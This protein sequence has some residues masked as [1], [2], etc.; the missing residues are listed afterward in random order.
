MS[1]N[2]YIGEASIAYSIED[3]E[4]YSETGVT[5]LHL[6]VNK[7]VLPN[8]PCFE[9]DELSH[10]NNGRH[11]AYTTWHDFTIDTDME[12]IWYDKYDGILGNH[13]GIVLLTEKMLNVFKEKLSMYKEKHPNAIPRMENTI[14]DA[15]LA[16]LE[17]LVWWAEYAIGHCRIPAIYNQ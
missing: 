4:K 9:N 13:P 16:M 8:A 2:I 7:M 1:Y 17:W 5:P 15:R 3:L 10:N 11:P 12:K 14:E 6:I